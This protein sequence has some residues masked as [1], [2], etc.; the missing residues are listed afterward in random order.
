LAWSVVAQGGGQAI[1]AWF[2]A[3]P[4]PPFGSVGYEQGGGH[5]KADPDAPSY[6]G[7]GWGQ[8]AGVP[9]GVAYCGQG[10]GHP[11]GVPLVVAYCGQGWGHATALPFAPYWGQGC[12]HATALPLVAY[13]GQGWGHATAL[14]LAPSY[15]G[16]GGGQATGVPFVVAY[17]GHG[18]GQGRD[19]WAEPVAGGHGGGHARP[20]WASVVA[21]CGQG[22][23]HDPSGWGLPEQGGGHGRSG[24]AEAPVVGDAGW[25]Q[26][27]GHARVELAEPGRGQGGGH[28]FAAGQQAA[29]SHG[30][31]QGRLGE[32]LRGHGGWARIA[33]LVAARSMA[34]AVVVVDASVVG[35]DAGAGA[36][37]SVPDRAESAAGRE[38]DGPPAIVATD[39]AARDPGSAC[40]TATRASTM[41]APVVATRSARGETRR[42]QRRCTDLTSPPPNEA[43]GRPIRARPQPVRL[44][45]SEPCTRL[46]AGSG[47]DQPPPAKKIL[48]QTTRRR[49]CAPRRHRHESFVD[50]PAPQAG[51]SKDDAAGIKPV[52]SLTPARPGRLRRSSGPVRSNRPSGPARR[53]AADRRCAPTTR[54]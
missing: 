46:V 27:G 14:P 30:G 6:W 42:I 17:C 8:A 45:A 12:G 47:L 15:C 28:G 49:R 21:P 33:A 26:G 1:I 25:A 41:A 11:A 52:T 51:S 31:R 37:A 48:G 2:V 44:S 22:G 36:A 9:V 50:E 43:R 39:S 19:G 18:G 54:R 10:C 5:A 35:G 16:H 4:V 7:Q 3:A 38:A 13:W 24:P 32:E 53:P 29:G 34:P 40:D 23:G 20:V